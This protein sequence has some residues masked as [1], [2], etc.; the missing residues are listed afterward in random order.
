MES[1]RGVTCLKA[2]NVSA[3]KDG[4][5]RVGAFARLKKNRSLVC[6]EESVGNEGNGEKLET[7]SLGPP[8]RA[9]LGRSTWANISW[10]CREKKANSNA[11]ESRSRT[12]SPG[13]CGRERRAPQSAWAAGNGVST[14]HEH[15]L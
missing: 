7:R 2:A 9:I 4:I 15:Y 10:I 3:R 14:I 13:E 6:W 1:T 11:L 5:Q 12:P 8:D